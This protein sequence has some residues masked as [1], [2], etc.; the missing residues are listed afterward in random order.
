[1]WAVSRKLDHGDA[2]NLDAFWDASPD[3]RQHRD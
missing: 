2:T 1:M 3:A